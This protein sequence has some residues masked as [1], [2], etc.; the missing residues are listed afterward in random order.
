[1]FLRL[2]LVILLVSGCSS[3]E[4]EVQLT[5]VVTDTVQVQEYFP[6]RS[7]VG[8]LNAQDD[9]QIQARVSGYLTS[10]DFKEGENVEAG[11]PLYTIDPREFEAAL[12]SAK[13][14]LAAAQADREV[15]RLNFRRG[16]E[17]LPKSAISQADFDSLKA[18]MLEADAGYAQAEAA[19]KT[20]EV[21][22]T[23]TSI[24]APITGRIGR[25]EATVGDLVGPNSGVLTTLVSMDPIEAI[26]QISE[27]TFVA[28]SEERLQ[29]DSNGDVE[30]GDIQV[31]LELTNRQMYPLT[32]YIDYFANRIDDNTGTLETRAL[33]PNPSGL[34]VPGQYVRVIL[35]LSNPLTGTFIPQ[36][37]VQADQQGSFVL[38]IEPGDVVARRNVE[39][40]DRLDANIQV[41]SGVDSGEDVIVRGLQLV[42][43]GQVVKTRHVADAED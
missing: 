26:F 34:L 24:E 39:L 9:V 33:I 15:S 37:A 14:M 22:L 16:E 13:A 5:E 42:R 17:L 25:S 8:R 38:V 43:P 35:Q 19:V 10:V 6:K 18:K 27:S 2:L 31:S 1:M 29:P 3:E 11:D 21:N 20:A 4:A 30:L 12:A 7:F 28:T 36:A 23:Y 41:I 40:G 32:G